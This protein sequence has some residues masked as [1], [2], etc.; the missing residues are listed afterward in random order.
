MKVSN[1]NARYDELQILLIEEIVTTLREG[2]RE[3]G[4][5]DPRLIAD[6]TSTLA[7][8]IAAILDGTHELTV[9]GVEVVPV[10]TFASERDGDEL[11]APESGGSWMLDYVPALVSKGADTGRD[12][13]DEFDESID[14]G[15]DEER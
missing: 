8:S 2:L 3:A 9:D 6:A 11:I 5:G 1:D 12:D 14:L 13:D 7:F 4:V 10:V 15:G